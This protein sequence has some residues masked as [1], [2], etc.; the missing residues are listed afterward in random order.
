MQP[1]NQQPQPSPYDFILNHG[2]PAPKSVL[3]G[4]GGSK[5]MRIL[6][7]IILGLVLII[8]GFVAFTWLTSI[9]KSSAKDLLDPAQKQTEIIRVS[10]LISQKAKDPATIALAK[11]TELSVITQQKD[12]LALV[13]KLKTSF[14]IQQLNGAKGT[15]TDQILQTAE[16]NNRYD[17]AGTS[18]IKQL[19]TDYKK[20]LETALSKN[21]SIDQ[22]Q[23]LESSIQQVS[24][25]LGQ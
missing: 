7:V 21:K 11:T 17:E 4:T 19:L 1:E 22:K 2:E 12:T 8:G 5:K 3:P 20:S 23:L 24:L 16:Q 9:G 15:K 14:T 25:L 10:G 6:V 18:I 13:K